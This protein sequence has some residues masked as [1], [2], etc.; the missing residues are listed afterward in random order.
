MFGCAIMEF[1]L[2]NTF[3]SISSL[4]GD[5]IQC[6]EVNN[7]DSFEYGKVRLI[8]INMRPI[9]TTISLEYKGNIYAL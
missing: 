2:T 3:K 7:R 9:N 6:V 5:V 8:T 4:G 1:H